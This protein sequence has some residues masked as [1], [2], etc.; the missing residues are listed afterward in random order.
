MAFNLFL[1]KGF[2]NIDKYIKSI[3]CYI[4]CIGVL[5]LFRYVVQK[6]RWEGYME[7]INK[8][9]FQIYAEILRLKGPCHET[10]SSN[11]PLY[12]GSINW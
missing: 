11:S 2:D 5:L 6:Q 3:K 12:R 10:F 1:Y 9:P 7:K 8:E 4:L